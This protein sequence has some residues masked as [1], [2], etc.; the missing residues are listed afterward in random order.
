MRGS[1]GKKA[2]AAKPQ[3]LKAAGG[4]SKVLSPLWPGDS[5]FVVNNMLAWKRDLAGQLES[6]PVCEG[7]MLH[8][9]SAANP[10]SATIVCDQQYLTVRESPNKSSNSKSPTLPTPLR[11]TCEAHT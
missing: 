2:A 4:V 9:S 7:H 11:N 5:M 3:V 1:K 6:R 8:Q 10:L